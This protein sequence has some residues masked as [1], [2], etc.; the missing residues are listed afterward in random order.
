MR[1]AQVPQ[2]PGLPQALWAPQVLRVR[3]SLR[4]LGARQMPPVLRALAALRGRVP[5]ARVAA[6][7]EVVAG[8][9]GPGRGLP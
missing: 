3:R 1:R 2:V 4:V 5:G 7:G 6:A 8:A 9:R